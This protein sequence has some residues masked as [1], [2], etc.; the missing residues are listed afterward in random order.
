MRILYDREVDALYIEL[1]PLA[2]GTAENREL[3]EDIIADYSPDGQLAG[4]EILDA[5]LVLG[6]QLKE[7]IVED[8]SVGVIHQLALLMK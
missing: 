7:I 4:L 3:S 1:L 2:P 8:A 6:E 5:S